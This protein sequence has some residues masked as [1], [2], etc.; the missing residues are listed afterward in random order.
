[1]EYNSGI[2]RNK[3]LIQCYMWMSLE[4]IMLSER[5]QTQRSHLY[6]IF[7]IGKFI[8]TECK[9]VAARGKGKIGSDYLTGTGFLL[10]Q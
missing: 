3:V 4:N 7:R 2:K 5:N 1:M 9:L 10:G 8:E 6:K